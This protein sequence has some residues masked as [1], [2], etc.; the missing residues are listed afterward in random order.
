MMEIIFYRCNPGDEALGAA[1]DF[2]VLLPYRLLFYGLIRHAAV[3]LDLLPSLLPS[4]LPRGP[5]PA[6][7][8]PSRGPSLFQSPYAK[9]NVL[10]YLVG[11]RGFE[12]P[13]SCSQS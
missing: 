1:R 13:T 4:L 5:I 11:A 3:L 7:C 9:R 12:P 2:T 6:Q 8:A 10:F